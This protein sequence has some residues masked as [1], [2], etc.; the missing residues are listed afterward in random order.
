MRDG[1][2]CLQGW[3]LQLRCEDGGCHAGWVALMA[4]PLMVRTFLPLPPSPA[5]QWL[6]P[7]VLYNYGANIVGEQGAQPF[8]FREH[9]FMQNPRYCRQ[10]GWMQRTLPSCR[11]SG[12]AGREEVGRRGRRGGCIHM[13]VCTPPLSCPP[14][15]NLSPLPSRC[16]FPPEYLKEKMLV[17]MPGDKPCDDAGERS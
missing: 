6:R 10:E 12:T 15:S 16:R 2:G 17:V 3:R 1:F 13:A 4:F 9:S 14:P 5:W 11:T 8:D 7:K